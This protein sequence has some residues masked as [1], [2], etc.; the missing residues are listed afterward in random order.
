MLSPFPLP[1]ELMLTT[2]RAEREDVHGVMMLHKQ[3]SVMD[4][5]LIVIAAATK[6]QAA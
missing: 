1:G 4:F 3:V 2:E 6:C 5:S